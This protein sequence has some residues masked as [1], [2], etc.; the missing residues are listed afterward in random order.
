MGAGTS[1]PRTGPP[2]I[3]TTPPG[4]VWTSLERSC[5]VMTCSSSPPQAQQDR[6]SSTGPQSP[7]VPW[8]PGR[9]PT[10]PSLRETTRSARAWLPP[11]VLRQQQKDQRQCHQ[12]QQQPLSHR[13]P[14]QTLEQS[15]LLNVKQQSLLKL[16]AITPIGLTTEMVR[17]MCFTICFSCNYFR[18]WKIPGGGH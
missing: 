13:T 16:Y 1:R 11:A 9:L 5:S 14:P 3:L 17:K 2:I 7:P 15:P 18:R 12:V 10:A 4:S 6:W 8:L